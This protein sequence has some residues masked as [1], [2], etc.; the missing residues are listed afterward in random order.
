MLLYNKFFINS[1][2]IKNEPY[3]N[4]IRLVSAE[5]LLYNIFNQDLDAFFFVMKNIATPMPAATTTPMTT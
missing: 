5:N 1:I 2:I 4:F 3:E